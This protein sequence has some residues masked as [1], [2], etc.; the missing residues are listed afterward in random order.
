MTRQ[1]YTW[2]AMVS[3][4]SWTG[5][6]TKP[7]MSGGRCLTTHWMTWL[8]CML[9]MHSM[10]CPVSSDANGA[11]SSSGSNSTIFWTRRHPIL[12]VLNAKISPLI[13]SASSFRCSSVALSVSFCSTTLAWSL[14]AICAALGRSS[15][16]SL[17]LSSSETPG[18]SLCARN[19]LPAGSFTAVSSR[20][21]TSSSEN[22]ASGPVP[23][24]ASSAPRLRLP[25]CCCCCR[26]PFLPPGPSR[27]VCGGPP[28]PR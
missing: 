3:T 6:R 18:S 13:A 21:S 5:S 9:S 15:S 17:S 14:L 16:K 27:S 7:T 11:R 20:D 2:T 26:P 4:F 19:L 22:F 1:P 12:C 25:L 24:C 10:I 28:F 8:P 23:P